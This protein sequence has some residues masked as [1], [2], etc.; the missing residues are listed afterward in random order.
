NPVTTD[1]YTATRSFSWQFNA[2]GEVEMV[3][4]TKTTLGLSDLL[5]GGSSSSDPQA[6]EVD[7]V[8]LDGVMEDY[9]RVMNGARLG[10]DDRVRLEAYIEILHDSVRAAA[11]AGT[12]CSSTTLGEEVDIDATVTNQFRLLA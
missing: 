3:R 5:L 9:R 7:Q 4:P 1:D 12:A 2:L 11:P 8:L 6:A 10:A